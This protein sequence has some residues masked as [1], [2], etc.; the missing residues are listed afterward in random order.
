MTE[1]Y[2]PVQKKLERLKARGMIS[3]DLLWTQFKVD[4]QVTG[5]DEDSGLPVSALLC[6]TCLSQVLVRLR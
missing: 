6:F 5:T 2:G 3:F 4:G 1:E